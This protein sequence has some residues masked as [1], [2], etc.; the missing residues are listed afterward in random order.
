MPQFRFVEGITAARHVLPPDDP[1][2]KTGGA[3]LCARIMEP[4]GREPGKKYPVLIYVYGGPFPGGLGLN[5]VVVNY[6]QHVPDLWLRTMASAGFGIFSLDNRGSSGAVRGHDF[7]TPIHRQLGHVELA[8]QVEG[9]KYLKTL[10]WVDPRRIG[11]FGGS[12]GGFMSLTTLAK[13]PVENQVSV[14]TA[15]APVVGW[16]HFDALY[17][18]RYMGL[19]SDNDAYYQDTSANRIAGALDPDLRLLL[20]HGSDDS[21]V[22]LTHSMRMVDALQNTNRSLIGDLMVY[23]H[24]RHASFFDFGTK[25]VQ[26]FSKVTNFLIANLRDRETPGTH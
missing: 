17:T 4:A 21:T 11:I 16:D 3:P 8:D 7:E 25:P 22:H 20:V 12:Y 19:P 9:I 2:H 26:I 1:A 10:D 24:S 15:F 23:P 18:E 13:A 5:R 14:A 6:W